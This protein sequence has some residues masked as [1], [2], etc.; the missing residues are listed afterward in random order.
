MPKS[1]EK[2]LT[3][4]MVI[5]ELMRSASGP[6]PAHELA[7]QML[8]ALPS[9]ARNPQQA[10]R[11]HIRQANGRQLVFLDADTVLPLRLAY[12]EARFRIPLERDSFDK[13]LL[14]LDKIS[15]CLPQG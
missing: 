13:G 6:L 4:E 1:T 15:S 8:S 11:Q 5:A 9:S 10:M 14:P 2:S 12:Q 3:Y 7:A